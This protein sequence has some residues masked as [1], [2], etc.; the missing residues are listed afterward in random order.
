MWW[1]VIASFFF[2]G[3]GQGLV[4]RRLRALVWAIAALAAVVGIVWSMWLAP[5]ALLAHLGAA[6]DAG[7]VLRRDARPGGLDRMFG[8]AV[9]VIGAVGFGLARLAVE[10]FHVPTSSMYPTIEIGD[11]IFV[12][13]L[14]KL[15]R[16]VE[17]GELI[18]SRYPCDPRLNY[19]KRVVALGGDTV[20]IRC[21]VLYVNGKAVP[22][23]LV[24]KDW[25]YEDRDDENQPI[26]KQVSRW[27]EEL[28]GHSYDVFEGIGEP[29]GRDFPAL[30]RPFPPGCADES[31]FREPRKTHEVKGELVRTKTGVGACEPQFH[32][33]VP[34]GAV[35]G[36][37]DNRYNGVD[38]RVYGAVSQDD[39]IGRVI[40]VLLNNQL[41]TF[42]RFGALH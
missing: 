41:G 25:E 19:I 11:H 16:P 10:G 30:D 40:G 32:Y 12:D 33:V 18:V 23:T 35:F 34:K 6:I 37:S 26:R 39:I 42:G 13:K 17:R 27:H 20:E 24:A 31:M 5:I 3:F 36:L 8:A 2:P 22:H 1:M 14:T 7:V 29:G 38:S 21:D 15:W 4:H 28:D 9:I